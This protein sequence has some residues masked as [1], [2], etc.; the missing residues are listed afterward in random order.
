MVYSLDFDGAP[1][2]F[3]DILDFPLED[4]EMGPD[5][6]DWTDMQFYDL[7]LDF[8]EGFSTG[9]VGGV[10]NDCPKE[11]RPNINLP[12]SYDNACRL[13]EFP[14]A[15]AGD[16]LRSLD[17]FD[18][19]HG[20]L[21]KTS[22]PVSIL[23]S[24][25]SCF[26]ENQKPVYQKFIPVKRARTKRSRSRRSNFN[27]LCS[28]FS[29]SEFSS[30]PKSNHLEPDSRTFHTGKMFK[31]A[32]KRPFRTK[33]TMFHVSGVENFNFEE[34]STT[35]RCTHCEVTNTPQWREGPLGPKT[36][37]NACGVRYR[38][39]RLFPEYRPAASPT[40]VPSVHSN[41]HKK[42]LEMRGKASQSTNSIRAGV[43][44]CCRSQSGKSVR[45]LIV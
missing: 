30:S 23:E 37:C 7:P 16:I 12:N 25:S 11:T 45:Q 42:V 38:S 1:K 18:S 22:S 44:L 4:V 21:F 6:D 41:S 10:K 35:K 2:D 43:E 19:K 8:S 33:K 40:F 3:F 27:Q 29:H 14:S 17:S 9:F 24:T 28:I 26:G 39:G 15:S 20:R 34:Q 36:L 13:K 5:R 32:V 31:P